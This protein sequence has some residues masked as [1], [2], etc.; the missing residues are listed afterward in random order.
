[1]AI[2]I[3]EASG[4]GSVAV[5]GNATGHSSVGMLGK[6]E[7]V[8][9]RGE[10]KT[11]H[12]VVGFSESTTGGFGVYG[13]GLGGGPGVVGKSK[14][15]H[16]IAGF[17]ESPSGF[18]IYGEANGS[19][20]V[21]VSKSWHGVYGESPSTSGGAGVWGEH[22]ANGTGVVG[23][24]NGGV[25]VWGISD[26][27]E[28]MHAE[29]NSGQTAALAAYNNNAASTA[30]AIYARKTGTSGHAGFFE[31]N[32]YITGIL[33]ADNILCP[34]ADFAE[35]FP[36]SIAQS[37]EPGMLMILAENGSLVPC[38]Q[39]YDRRAAG[40]ISGAGSYQPGV[41]LDHKKD[42]TDR[43]PIA[44]LG[45]VCCYVDA[46]YGAIR[47]GDLLTTSP[48]RGH[49]MRASDAALAFGAVIG[50]ALEPLESGRRLIPVLVCS[51]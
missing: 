45:K 10:G 30:A 40:I 35:D 19:G 5:S 4:D 11:W 31:G 32:V 18:G 8:G 36:I 17:S 48:T 16:A 1:M 7:A 29:T 15:W 21:G 37:P 49:A 43:M 20:V 26:T 2:L 9:L 24:S 46:E 23:K 34:H 39:A 27:H 38:A 12:G 14:G 13:E 50:K 47:V 6:G 28:G 33:H 42:A 51:C 3:G 44:L 25:G 22:K 41:V